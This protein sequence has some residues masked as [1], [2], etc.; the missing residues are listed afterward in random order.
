MNYLEE[1][2]K[3]AKY[4]QVM[5]P[6]AYVLND[7]RFVVWSGSHL[8]RAHHYGEGGLL[9]H[10]YEVCKISGMMYEMF[11]DRYPELDICVLFLAALFH[12]YGKI[13]DYTYDEAA[14]SWTANIHKRKIHHIQRSALEWEK[15]ARACSLPPKFIEEVTHCI[16]SHH[17]QR[18]WGSAVAPYTREAWILHLADG[19]SARIDDC[20]RVDLATL[21]SK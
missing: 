19:M 11:K 10:T 21:K 12:D 18:N 9:R 1:L 20:E 2:R 16:L 17:G 4:A 8:E 15:I 13:W 14:K 3:M 6:A 7:K 5:G